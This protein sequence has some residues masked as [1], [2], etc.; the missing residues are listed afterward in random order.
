MTATLIFMSAKLIFTYDFH[1]WFSRKAV[2]CK[3]VNFARKYT[4][5]NNNYL[6]K[7]VRGLKIYS[8]CFSP[9]IYYPFNR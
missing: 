2:N 8:D 6:S 7:I 5:I 4:Y 9:Q 3:A 1:L